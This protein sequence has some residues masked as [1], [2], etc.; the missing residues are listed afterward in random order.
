MINTKD[1]G[2]GV[3]SSEDQIAKILS[4]LGPLSQDDKSFIDVKSKLSYLEYFQNFVAKNAQSNKD[5][6]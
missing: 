5:S 6:A 3:Y 1:E 2:K 4:K